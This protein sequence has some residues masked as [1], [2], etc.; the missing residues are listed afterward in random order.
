[1][2]LIRIQW[3]GVCLLALAG[4]ASAPD[5][6]DTTV[7]TKDERCQIT[8]SNLPRRDCR[9]DNTVLPP[10]A[11]DSVMPVLPPAGMRP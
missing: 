9:G 3:V 5:S 11:V 7:V 4:C 2:S 10:S 6:K 8:G 1:M